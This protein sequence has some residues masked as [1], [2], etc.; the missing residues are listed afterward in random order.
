MVDQLTQ[1]TTQQRDRLPAFVD[2]WIAKAQS[3]TPL[4]ETEWHAWEAGMRGYYFDAGVS[5]PGVVV[6][7]G[8]PIVGALAAPVALTVL[9]ERRRRPQRRRATNSAAIEAAVDAVI[10]STVEPWLHSPIREGIEPTITSTLRS[11]VAAAASSAAC[12]ALDSKP[13]RADDLQTGGRRS[14]WVKPAQVTPPEPKALGAAVDRRIYREVF[15]QTCWRVFRATDLAIDLAVGLAVT[16]SIPVRWHRVPLERSYSWPIVTAF[17]RDEVELPLAD[18]LWQRSREYQDAL[19]TRWWWPTRDFVMVCDRPVELHVEA[20][21]DSHRLHNA[22]GPAIR[23]ADGWALY[24]WHGIRVPADLIET[25]WTPERILAESN[26]EIRRCAVERMGW[27]RFAAAAELVE[28][29]RAADPA[30]P[31]QL[32][33]LY[34]VPDRLLDNA[35]RVLVCTNATR[36][37]DGSRRSFGLTVPVDCRRALTAAAWTFDLAEAEYVT[38][39]RAT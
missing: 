3:T 30:N 28:L 18:E 14:A 6:R 23:W 31:G 5:W 34:D 7:V 13:S 1:L 2:E 32:L 22:V 29:D 26:V 12:A 20:T 10:T 39:A 17:F 4:T 35:A 36:E 11:A 9:R 15:G 19:L 27:D 8:S 37:R 38:L 25:D 24:F 21:A 16:T 33:L